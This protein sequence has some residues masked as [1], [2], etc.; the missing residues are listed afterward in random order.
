MGARE[1]RT[2]PQ[3]EGWGTA[4]LGAGMFRRREMGL[5]LG[6]SAGLL[7]PG[8]QDRCQLLA[9]MKSS[10]LNMLSKEHSRN[11]SVPIPRSLGSCGNCSSPSGSEAKPAAPRPHPADGSPWRAPVASGPGFCAW[12]CLGPGLM[13]EARPAPDT[14]RVQGLRGLGDS[15]LTHCSPGLRK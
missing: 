6:P 11:I 9:S 13:G 1:M 14:C 4:C 8:T 3:S 10:V 7:A 5:S 12:P 15:P 2:Q